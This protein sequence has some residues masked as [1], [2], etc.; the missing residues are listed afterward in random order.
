MTLLYRGSAHG[1]L[2]KD[3][4]DNCD[5]KGPTISLFQ[6]KDGDCIGG[7]TSA[8]WRSYESD[9]GL[10]IEDETAFLF[11]LTRK[12]SFPIDKQYERVAI[13]SSKYKGPSFGE[14]YELSANCSPLNTE[15]GC[16]S[17]RDEMSFRIS[18]DSEGK[19]MLTNRYFEFHSRSEFTISE[20]EVWGITFEKWAK[21]LLEEIED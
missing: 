11:N 3:F 20:L 13:R 19:N 14:N 15:N 12:R 4:H 1:W 2:A 21:F 16:W 6:I 7:F 10:S 5:D 18:C 8:W 17:Y 9:S